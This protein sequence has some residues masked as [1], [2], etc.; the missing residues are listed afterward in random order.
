MV[1]L[2]ALPS[3]F[4]GKRFA[5]LV[6]QCL[7]IVFVLLSAAITAAIAGHLA[8]RRSPRERSW[9][10][11]LS[12]TAVLCYYPLSYWSLMGME[13]G[14]L[15]SLLLLATLA[16]FRSPDAGRRWLVA[17]ALALGLAYLT[18]PDSLVIAAV[19]LVIA[20]SEHRMAGH[21]WRGIAIRLLPAAAGLLFVV[22]VHLAFRR[23]YYGQW[24]PNTYLLKVAGVPAAYRVREGV[25][26]TGPFLKS[27]ALFLALGAAGLLSGWRRRALSLLAIPLGLVLVQVWAGGDP[28]PYWRLVAPGVPLLCLV[29]ILQ[30]GTMRSAIAGA[31]SSA[32]CRPCIYLARSAALSWLLVAGVVGLGLAWA[33]SAFWPEVTFR[34]SPYSS[35]ENAGL[36]SSAL[37]LQEVTREAATVG[38]LWAGAVPYYSGRVG[39]DFLGKCDA[40]V[41]RLAPDTVGR[42][43]WAGRPGHNKYDLGYSIQVREPTYVQQ[44]N[45][46]RDDIREWAQDHYVGVLYRGVVLYLRNGSPTVRWDALSEAAASEAGD[47]HGMPANASIVYALDLGSD[48]EATLREA[49]GIESAQISSG[50]LSLT[51]MSEDGHFTLFADLRPEVRPPL[52][53]RVGMSNTAL[54]AKGAV[55]WSSDATFSQDRSLSWPLPGDGRMHTYFLCVAA[56]RPVTHLR[57]DPSDTVDVIRISRLDVCTSAAEQRSAVGGRKKAIAGKGESRR[58]RS[59]GA[60]ARLVLDDTARRVKMRSAVWLAMVVVIGA[61]TGVMLSGC[62]GPEAG[63]SG[64]PSPTP[65]AGR[66]QAGPVAVGA[67][68]PANASSVFALDLSQEGPAKLVDARGVASARIANGVLELAPA[69]ED[70]NF[71]LFPKRTDGIRPP[72]WLKVEMSNT[73]PKAFGQVYWSE[74]GRLSEASSAKWKLPGDGQMHTY[75]VEIKAFRPVIYLRFDPSNRKETV[76]IGLLEVF[77][78]R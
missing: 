61:A 3:L 34:K 2:M 78:G 68:L 54:G 5:V 37:A 42:A 33:N 40:V 36:V 63:P 38:V 50:V 73:V 25:G 55:Y 27:N 16:A 44:F 59:V 47:R 48:G 24:L 57:F 13:T 70:C 64:A 29:A 60:W 41:A 18:R 76:K 67:V 10:A 12:F 8:R 30:L 28:W 32:R 11:A 21:R 31:S 9:I 6:I 74:G 17:L 20:I 1:L 72:L 23:A 35:R 58:Q 45:W 69:S 53:L 77:S 66:P 75:T 65:E 7:G 43:S 22:G 19:V 49:W 4:L 51:T 71:G 52:W 15:T 62:G 14:L 26:Y 39:V 56:D 46:G